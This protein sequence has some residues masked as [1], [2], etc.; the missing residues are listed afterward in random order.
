[1]SQSD[2]LAKSLQRLKKGGL[3]AAVKPFVIWV[4]LYIPQPVFKRVKFNFG[5]LQGA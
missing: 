2:F 1:M 4:M 3:V 5:R